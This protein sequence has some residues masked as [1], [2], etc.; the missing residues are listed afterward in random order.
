MYAPRIEN[1]L[2]E[3]Y[4][5]WLMA[6]DRTEYLKAWREANKERVKAWREANK[7]HLRTNYKRWREANRERRDAYM[8]DWRE[9][10]KEHTREYN[11]AYQENN[12]E[13]I[14]PLMQEYRA[15]NREALNAKSR[16]RYHE[17]Y[18]ESAREH[19]YQSKYG[20]SVAQ[21]EE[22]LARQGGL[23]AI[24]R[25]PPTRKR[26]YIDHCHTTLVVRGLLCQKCNHAI[27]LLGDDPALCEAAGRYLLASRPCG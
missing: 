13:W 8:R 5:A 9:A 23:C 4:D 6:K 15:D 17:R 3:W 1:R 12:K 24:C 11:K 18:T 2:C 25:K 26:L 7:E 19:Q 14:K 20:I 16:Q 10:N 21:Y 27:G 22:M